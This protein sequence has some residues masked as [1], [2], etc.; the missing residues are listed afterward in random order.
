MGLGLGLGM[1]GFSLSSENLMV[2]LCLLLGNC[3]F[4]RSNDKGA[5]SMDGLLTWLIELY[6]PSRGDLFIVGQV[7]AKSQKS[8]SQTGG[9]QV[10]S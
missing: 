5:E 1:A 3:Q 7:S 6:D 4:R 2:Y 8:Q 9:F 10:I